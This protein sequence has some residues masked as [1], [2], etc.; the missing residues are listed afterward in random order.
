MR[1]HSARDRQASQAILPP[2]MEHS[3]RGGLGFR[4]GYC[5]CRMILGPAVSPPGD[6][7][8]ED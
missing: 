1:V 3:V 7:K 6:E 4:R 2:G 5:S 8:A